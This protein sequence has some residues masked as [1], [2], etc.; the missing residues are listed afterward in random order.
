MIANAKSTSSEQG[1]I[2]LAL[3]IIGFIFK[4]TLLGMT[5]CI[6]LETAMLVA[7]VPA[8]KPFCLLLVYM[9]LTHS[10]WISK[11]M[12]SVKV[13]HVAMLSASRAAVAH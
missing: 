10:Q 13:E 4:K 6:S 9:S 12:R 11:K 8:G 3:T 7:G 5:D 1:F 2:T